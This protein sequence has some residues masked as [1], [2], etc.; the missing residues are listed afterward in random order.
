MNSSNIEKVYDANNLYISNPVVFGAGR[1][2]ILH[3]YAS[4]C[5]TPEKKKEF[6]TF[7]ENVFGPTIK[8]LEC[9]NHFLAMLEKYPVP[10]G[11]RRHPRGREWGEEDS[12]FKWTYSVHNIVNNRLNKPI[13]PWEVCIKL[14]DINNVCTQCFHQF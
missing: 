8:C 2:E 13:M 5:K 3:S 4:L 11:S 1:W 14:Y 6:A 7:V 9:R 10:F 12:V